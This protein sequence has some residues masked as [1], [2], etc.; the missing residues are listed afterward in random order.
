VAGG[1]GI[2]GNLAMALTRKPPQDTFLYSCQVLMSFLPSSL[3]WFPHEPQVSAYFSNA[4]TKV[5]EAALSVS[6]GG[7]PAISVFLLDR[8]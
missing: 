2:L 4:S 8:N 6:L 1:G 3:G 7:H 5:D